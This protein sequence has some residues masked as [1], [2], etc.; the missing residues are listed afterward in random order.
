MTDP[1]QAAIGIVVVLIAVGALLYVFYS[2]TNSV[3][4]T[5]YGAL[6]ML[7]V[8]SLMIPVFWIT[9]SNAQAVAKVQQHTTDVNRGAVLFAQYCF[10][11]HGINGQGLVGAKLNGNPAVNKLTDADILR[12]IS[13]GVANTADPS[14]FLMPAWSEQ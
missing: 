14:Q 4:K 5:G 10:Q 11:C 13:G 7:A 1:V 12:I 3:E 8:V 6:I 2:R 9:E